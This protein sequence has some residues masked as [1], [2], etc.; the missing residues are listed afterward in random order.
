[1]QNQRARSFPTPIGLGPFV[2]S[3]G[4]AHASGLILKELD[5]QRNGTAGGPFVLA[6]TPGSTGDVQ[7]RPSI[8]LGKAGKEAGRSNRPG[9][10]A[11]DVGD[12]RKAGTKLLLIGVVQR[13]AP[14]RVV[15]GATGLEQALGKFVVFREQSGVDM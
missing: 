15:G 14:R 13:H 2:L 9:R 6:G 7:V 5:Q 4:K 1:M 12:I 8:F 11:T 3:A 10:W